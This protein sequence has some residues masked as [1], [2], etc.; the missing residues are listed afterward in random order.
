MNRLHCDAPVCR[1]PRP[2]APQAAPGSFVLV[3]LVGPWGMAAA[4]GPVQQELYRW[5]W[6]QACEVARPSLP[7]RDLLAVWN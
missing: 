4:M 7:E 5:A 6:E 1:L 2:S 3:P